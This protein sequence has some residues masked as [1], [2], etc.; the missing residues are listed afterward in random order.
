MAP[1]DE[2]TT[3][4]RRALAG[5]ERAW[6]ELMRR[7]HRRV[8]VFAMARLRVG[9]EEAEDLTQQAWLVLTQ[10]LREGRLVMLDLPGL[11][12]AQVRYLHLNRLKHKGRA[13]EGEFDDSHSVPDPS[14][15]AEHSVARRDLVDRVRQVVEVDL[16]QRERD[17]L[18][19]GLSRGG[20]DAETAQTLQLSLQRVRE[21]KSAAYKKIRQVLAREGLP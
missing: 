5:D 17:V 1:P 21:L 13:A 3:L 6:N 11:A 7:H 2:I 9:D 4:C 19:Q 18:L 15:T 10:R 20:T 8:V 16:T 12:F 14:E